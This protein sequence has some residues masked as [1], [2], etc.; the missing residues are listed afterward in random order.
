MFGIT[1]NLCT[2]GWVFIIIT[3]QNTCFNF[4]TSEQVYSKKFEL[5]ERC[6]KLVVFLFYWD[7]H[8]LLSICARQCATFHFTSSR[9]S[10]SSMCTWWQSNN[11]SRFF[12]AEHALQSKLALQ[13]HVSGK[14]WFTYFHNLH[15]FG[16]NKLE[17]LLICYNLLGIQVSYSDDFS[18]STHK[19]VYTE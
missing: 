11:L 9:N 4:L 19:S 10:R 13:I 3:K 1:H 16:N 12:F 15:L 6:F 18:K 14:E 8:Q 2:A 7:H 5:S 17:K